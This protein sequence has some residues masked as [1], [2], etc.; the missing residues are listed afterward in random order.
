MEYFISVHF[1]SICIVVLAR[2]WGNYFNPVLEKNGELVKGKG[3]IT[4]DLTNHGIE[5]IKKNKNNPFFLYMP[6][7]TV[8]CKFQINIGINS[9]TKI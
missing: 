2:H 5:F 8:Q 7:H 3:F 1:R 9:K 4:D 6:R